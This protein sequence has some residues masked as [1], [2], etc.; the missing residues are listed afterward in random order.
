VHVDSPH[1]A[2]VFAYDG[3]NRGAWATGVRW[4]EMP[5]RDAG[6]LGWTVLAGDVAAELYRIRRRLQGIVGD[7]APVLAASGPTVSDLAGTARSF[8]EAEVVL[9][10]LRSRPGEVELTY[11]ALGF[12]GLLLSVPPE[13][14]RWFVDTHLGPIL[15]RS[16]LLETLAAWYEERGSRAA[17]ARRLHIHRNSVGY[18]IGRTRDLLGADPFDPWT[19][20]QLRAALVARDILAVRTSGD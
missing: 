2:A 12:G 5:V 19:A 17:V 13:R 16:D 7:D 8:A 18:R 10:L 15:D 4:I 6:G 20:L 1:A 11:E 3:T 9:A 14:L